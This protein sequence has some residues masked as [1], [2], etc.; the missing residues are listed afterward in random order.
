MHAVV[1]NAKPG[2]LAKLLAILSVA[3]FWLL[4]FSPM[5]AIG[6]VSI[7]RGTSGWSRNLAVT[8]A[9]LCI[10]YTLVMA[11]VVVRLTLQISR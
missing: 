9:V 6:A 8:G 3:C 5:V 1:A 11:L 7:T 2:R 4:P 10:A